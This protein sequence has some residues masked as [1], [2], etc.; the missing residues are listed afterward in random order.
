MQQ[1]YLTTLQ[2]WLHRHPLKQ[3]H[4][5]ADWYSLV[6]IGTPLHFLLALCHTRASCRHVTGA[7]VRHLPCAQEFDD[8]E[9]L[10]ARVLAA[11]SA[12]SSPLQ[13]LRIDIGA[14]GQLWAY[15]LPLMGSFA[16]TLRQLAFL[17]VG[18]LSNLESAAS[19]KR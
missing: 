3:L 2:Q 17:D 8:K 10:C 6:R 11:V 15:H 4:C 19:F 18:C 1:Q 14:G 12:S 5:S 9:L 16:Q 7:E 13:A